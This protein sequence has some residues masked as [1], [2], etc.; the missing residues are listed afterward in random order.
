MQ[1]APCARRE[2]RLGEVHHGA[3]RQRV[4]EIDQP[5]HDQFAAL[6][7]HND[8]A[9]M[10]V[11]V[12]EHGGAAR[13]HDFVEAGVQDPPELLGHCRIAAIVEEAPECVVGAGADEFAVGRVAGRSAAFREGAK[14]GSVTPW[15]VF[16]SA[17]SCRNTSG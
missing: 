16:A 7:G 6:L 3:A 11:V 2:H 17:P 9:G 1:P 8:V 5:R 10:E 12:G 4:A 13:R 14:A 15:S